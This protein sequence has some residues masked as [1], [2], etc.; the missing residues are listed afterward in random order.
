MVIKG[1][2][3]PLSVFLNAVAA[4]AGFRCSKRNCSVVSE[5]RGRSHATT[6]QAVLGL[7]SKADKMAPKGPALGKV[8][9]M[10]L[11]CWDNSFSWSCRHDIKTLLQKFPNNS[12][13]WWRCVCP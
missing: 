12:Y 6:S 2:G 4:L 3:K 10:V 7:N 11:Y 9:P 8:S 5:S 13:K 1:S